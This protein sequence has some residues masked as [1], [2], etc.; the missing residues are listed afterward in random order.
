MEATLSGS[1]IKALEARIVL[2]TSQEVM[3]PSFK[4]IYVV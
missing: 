3:A 1:H 4:L 2:F